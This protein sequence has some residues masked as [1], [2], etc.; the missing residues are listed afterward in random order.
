VFVWSHYDNSDEMHF[1]F[2]L[3]AFICNSARTSMPYFCCILDEDDPL[4]QFVDTLCVH[5]VTV[6]VSMMPLFC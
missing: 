3:D 2:M 4:P 1:E 6:S 5:G